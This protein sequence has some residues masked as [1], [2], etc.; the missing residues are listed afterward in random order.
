MADMA[1]LK[2]IVRSW[3]EREESRAGCLGSARRHSPAAPTYAVLGE[4]VARVIGWGLLLEYALVVAVVSIGWSGYLQGPA[5]PAW[6][7][8]VLRLRNRTI[9]MEGA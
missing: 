6:P 2:G 4:L 9:V 7:A 3:I 8:A 5:Q 1:V